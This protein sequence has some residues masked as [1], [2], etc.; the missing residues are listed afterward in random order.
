MAEVK[1]LFAQRSL[2]EVKVKRLQE[3][4]VDRDGTIRPSLA[5]VKLYESELQF[6]YQEYQREYG[7]ILSAIPEER[8]SDLDEDYQSFEDLHFDA[9]V[10][11]ETMLL[12]FPTT[13]NRYQHS[14]ASSTNYFPATTVPRWRTPLVRSRSPS[15]T[16]EQSVPI[17]DVMEEPNTSPL[18]KH[19]LEKQLFP[20]QANEVKVSSSAI[21]PILSVQPPSAEGSAKLNPECGPALVRSEGDLAEVIQ[22][23]SAPTPIVPPSDVPT[24]QKFPCEERV[25]SA[26]DF[27]KKLNHVCGP[28]LVRSECDLAEVIKSKS[29]ALPIVPPSDVPP[30]QKFPREERVPSAEASVHPVCGPA[31]DRSDGDLA[32][33]IQ[34]KSAPTPI[35]PPSVA[36]MLQKCLR[37]E[38]VPIQRE[39]VPTKHEQPAHREEDSTHRGKVP[40]WSEEVTT[41][42]YE[43]TSNP[44]CKLRKHPANPAK[45]TPE[46]FHVGNK[47]TQFVD[48]LSNI[49]S[50]EATNPIP[51]PINLVGIHPKSTPFQRATGCGA[52]P[53]SFLMPP[54][55]H[56]PPRLASMPTDVPKIL[57]NPAA[58]SQSFQCTTGSRPVLQRFPCVGGFRTIPIKFPRAIGLCL[59]AKRF[60]CRTRFRPAIPSRLVGFHPT[61]QRF[62]CVAGCIPALKHSSNLIESNSGVKPFQRVARFRPASKQ[63]SH[64]TGFRRTPQRFPCVAGSIPALKYSSSLTGSNSIEKP[65]QRVFPDMAGFP[66]VMK[67]PS[68]VMGYQPVSQGFPV[69]SEF[70]LVAKKFQCVAKI[71]PIRK[72]QSC[73]TGPRSVLKRF[74]PSVG[75]HPA[76]K[77]PPDVTGIPPPVPKPPDV[78]GIPPP[79]PNSFRL[80]IEMNPV[81]MF[82]LPTGI[83][84]VIKLA[85]PSTKMSARFKP[86]RMSADIPPI[87]K[88]ILKMN[89]TCLK[90]PCP[91]STGSH[92]VS[93]WLRCPTTI[94]PIARSIPTIAEIHPAK[95]PNPMPTGKRPVLSEAPNL[96]FTKKMMPPVNPT[97]DSMQAHIKSRPEKPPNEAPMRRRAS[98][99]IPE[100]VSRTH[101]PEDVHQAVSK[102][103][104]CGVCLFPILAQ[105]GF[106][107]LPLKSPTQNDIVL[108]EFFVL[109]VVNEFS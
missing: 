36:P 86:I 47:S 67:Q 7:E 54:S 15:P 18:R 98:E 100:C 79:V 93:K 70:H 55:F 31:L 80:P 104:I 24:L 43:D 13:D 45:T 62:P 51:V 3:Q 5:R 66:P 29:A 35:V 44:P 83:P 34:C 96:R 9:C 75:S 11:V 28:A 74:P 105:S 25:A 102:L 103:S 32:E 84:P 90:H 14:R 6:L 63:L 101:P 109:T 108:D 12:S 46:D 37:E 21:K 10:L 64:L 57:Q 22:C 8:F 89:E 26:E 16:T 19:S 4:L 94:P 48:S 65:F 41:V 59:V 39:E 91:L 52:L 85:L 53:K 40:T 92:S 50:C 20:V 17:P 2:V 38:N 97:G 73:A 60:P 30:L 1:R 76:P 61:P 49:P 23:K 99:A 87:S 42:A 106:P 72:Q 58:S 78:P 88:P 27:A 68:S 69:A 81:L 71:H 56:P 107:S 82:L 95:E 33:V 77:K